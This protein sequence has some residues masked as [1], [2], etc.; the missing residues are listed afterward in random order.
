MSV[1]G[2]LQTCQTSLPQACYMYDIDGGVHVTP[3]TRVHLYGPVTGILPA[4]IFIRVSSMYMHIYTNVRTS[5]IFIFIGS[6]YVLSEFWCLM[7]YCS[8]ECTL[9]RLQGLFKI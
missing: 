5:Y 2:H 8:T 1:A 3:L 9:T 4:C 7:E 6:S